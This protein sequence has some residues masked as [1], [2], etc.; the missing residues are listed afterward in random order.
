[1]AID[2]DNKYLWRMPRRRLEGEAIRDAIMAVAGNLDRTVG[3]PAVHPVHRSGA[4]PVEF[5]AYLDGK[6]DS[7]PSTWRRSV[8]VFSKRSIPLPMLEVF[9]RPDSVELV[10]TP[11][12][13]HD[14][15]A[16]ADPDE[17]RVRAD[18][19]EEVR[20]PA[21]QG[22]GS[23]T[24]RA[25][26]PCVPAYAQPQADREGTASSRSLSCAPDEQALPDFCQAMLNLNEFVYIQ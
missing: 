9:D 12:P 11:Q 18:G 19:G 4:V 5:E 14:R 16:G 1:M 21:A 3:G 17:Q 24:D 15:A 8:Y 20:R 22:G 10:R 7:D 26:R 13:Q 6:P 25:G 23:R 2:R